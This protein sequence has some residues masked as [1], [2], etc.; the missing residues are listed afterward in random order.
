MPKKC[1]IRFVVSGNSRNSLEKPFIPIVIMKDRTVYSSIVGQFLAI[2]YSTLQQNGYN[3]YGFH[4]LVGL[5]DEI[6][7]ANPQ[8]PLWSKPTRDSAGAIRLRLRR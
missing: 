8:N 5:L 6:I 2:K 1:C 7:Q 4:V 3:Q